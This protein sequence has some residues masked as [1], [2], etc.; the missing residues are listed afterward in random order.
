M[1]DKAIDAQKQ[2]ERNRSWLYDYVRN[3]KSKDTLSRIIYDLMSQPAPSSKK[4]NTIKEQA[5][6]NHKHLSITGLDSL[7]LV[8]SD[9]NKLLH[10]FPGDWVASIKYSGSYAPERLL[11][12]TGRCSYIFLDI[13]PNNLAEISIYNP[14]NNSESGCEMLCQGCLQAHVSASYPDKLAPATLECINNTVERIGRHEFHATHKDR[15]AKPGR[16]RSLAG[17]QELAVLWSSFVETAYEAPFADETE[18]WRTATKKA[19]KGMQYLSHTET[20]A[21]LEALSAYFYDLD[22]NADMDLLIRQYQDQVKLIEFKILSRH[23]A[24]LFQEM[25]DKGLKSFFNHWIK[26]VNIDSV[27]AETQS[28]HLNHHVPSL[29]VGMAMDDAKELGANLAQSLRIGDINTKDKRKVLHDLRISIRR[30]NDIWKDLDKS[31]QKFLRP[32]FLQLMH[33]SIN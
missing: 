18:N 4:K 13:N 28:R 21:V 1:Y 31:E 9:V 20:E 6:I 3:N 2:L 8:D 29:R 24:D 11:P 32:K 27:T 22:P 16:S 26:R 15:I 25:Q 17:K 19:L 23:I 12:R 33:S 7:G 5:K 10:A 30:F 14:L